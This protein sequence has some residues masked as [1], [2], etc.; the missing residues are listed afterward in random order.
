MTVKPMVMAINDGYNPVQVEQLCFYL[1]CSYF[2]SPNPDKPEMFYQ[3]AKPLLA[4]HSRRSLDLI[5]YHA[6]CFKAFTLGI[7]DDHSA[8]K[9]AVEAFK[10]GQFFL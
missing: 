1:S 8:L 7:E 2:L 4:L 9:I 6:K 5:S 3:I 10:P